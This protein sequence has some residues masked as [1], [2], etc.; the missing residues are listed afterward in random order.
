MRPADRADWKIVSVTAHRKISIPDQPRVRSAMKVLVQNPTI[1]AIYFGGALGGDTLALRAA[2]EF[3]TGP[4]PRLVVVLPD[5]EAAQPFAAR[6]WYHLADEVIELG[7][8]IT[9]DDGFQAYH[10]RNE[11]L[12]NICTSLV[13]FFSGQKKSGTGS[14]IDYARSLGVVVHE[15]PVGR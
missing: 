11:Y 6:Q 7:Y 2:A 4:K 9:Q 13:A 12:V 10:R 15:V 3:R 14:T 8:T 1:D 5:T